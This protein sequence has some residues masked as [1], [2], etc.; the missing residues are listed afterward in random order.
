MTRLGP[1]TNTAHA[2]TSPTAAR[3]T[4]TNPPS[5]SV[6]TVNARQGRSHR[7]G[8]VQVATARSGIT[9]TSTATVRRS[10]R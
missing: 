8:E 3:R 9:T 2:A 10:T 4:P 5:A 7:T 1:T 6:A